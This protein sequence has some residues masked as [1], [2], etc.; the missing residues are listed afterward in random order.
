MLLESEAIAAIIAETTMSSITLAR[1]AKAT[2]VPQPTRILHRSNPDTP[3]GFL[4]D[5]FYNDTA[6]SAGTPDEWVPSF[7]DVNASNSATGYKD[8]TLLNQYDIQTCSEK[9]QSITGCNASNIYLKRDLAINPDDV[10]CA[11][12]SSV[13]NVKRVFWGKS[14]F[15]HNQA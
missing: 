10:S 4:E 12:P 15:I 9:Y 1:R 3:L 2:C 5:S 8:F 11:N 7:V 13:T 14:A 6:L